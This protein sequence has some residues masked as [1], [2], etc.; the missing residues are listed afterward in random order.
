MR[1][2]VKRALSVV[3][4]AGSLFAGTAVFAATSADASSCQFYSG[5]PDNPG[6]TF[7]SKCYRTG[8][9]HRAVVDCYKWDGVN[10]T[11]DKTVY[12]RWV[13]GATYSSAYCAPPLEA[14]NGRTEFG[15]D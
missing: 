12:G 15:N 9:S 4:L 1:S 7:Y 8:K 5:T 11:Y 10:L 6:N 14:S 2:S 13:E 3:A